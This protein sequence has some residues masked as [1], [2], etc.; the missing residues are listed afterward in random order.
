MARRQNLDPVRPE[1]FMPTKQRLEV[2]DNHPNRPQPVRLEVGLTKLL[3]QPAMNRL[4]PPGAQP[5]A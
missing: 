2:V 3:D 4:T 1:I 5:S